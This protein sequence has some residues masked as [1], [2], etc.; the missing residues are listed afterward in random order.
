MVSVVGHVGD[1]EGTLSAE[2]SCIL[3]GD[4]SGKCPQCICTFTIY[5]RLNV[6]KGIMIMR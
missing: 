3:V 1:K 6:D 2:E 4:G 5:Y